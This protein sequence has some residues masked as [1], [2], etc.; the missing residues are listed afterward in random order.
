[1]QAQTPERAA[2][3]LRELQK[4]TFGPVGAKEPGAVRTLA[5]TALKRVEELGSAEARGHRAA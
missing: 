4:T 5:R 2:Q 3:V 1:M